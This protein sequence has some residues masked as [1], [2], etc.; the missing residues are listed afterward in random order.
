M[1]TFKDYIH[2]ERKT[3][4]IYDGHFHREKGGGVTGPPIRIKTD[5]GRVTHVHEQSNG[6]QTTEARSMNRFLYND[7]IEANL[8]SLPKGGPH[9]HMQTD[10]QHTS[11]EIMPETEG[12]GEESP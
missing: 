12:E 5:D 2:K 4:I 6:Q 1:S 11:Q 9:I 3:D 10:G 8:D 7:D